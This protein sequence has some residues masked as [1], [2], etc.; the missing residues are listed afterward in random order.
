MYMVVRYFALGLDHLSTVEDPSFS[1]IESQHE[2][3]K[4]LWK[5]FQLFSLYLI[6]KDL[7][8]FTEDGYLNAYQA[9]IVRNTIKKLLPEIR[10]QAVPLVD[11]FGLRDWTLASALG[12]Y[13]GNVYQALY[14]WAQKEPLNKTQ[15]VDGYEQYLKPLLQGKSKL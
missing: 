4:E 13:D 6:E 10:M 15:V 9:E 12:R 2:A 11:A 1:S 3:I 7:G 5:L 14:D 8:E